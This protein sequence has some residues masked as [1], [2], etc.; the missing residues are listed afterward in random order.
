[1]LPPEEQRRAKPVKHGFFGDYPVTGTA[2][3]A[4]VTGAALLGVASLV[5]T[6]LIK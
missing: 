1:M 4:W 3:W 2:Y 5:L 6:I